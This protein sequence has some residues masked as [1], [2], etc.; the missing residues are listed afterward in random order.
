MFSFGV[1]RE[2]M[3]SMATAIRTNIPANA[4][5]LKIFGRG[6]FSFFDESEFADVPLSDFEMTDVKVVD[7]SNKPEVKVVN[8]SNKPE[9][10]NRR[11]ISIK[12]VPITKPST[13]PTIGSH[14]YSPSSYPITIP[15]LMLVQSK[16]DSLSII[17]PGGV[18]LE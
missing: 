17:H 14:M 2:I 12:N 7:L 18:R 3:D 13:P 10:T 8:L 1:Y 6:S 15:A 9:I 5:S 16:S 4:R 11:K